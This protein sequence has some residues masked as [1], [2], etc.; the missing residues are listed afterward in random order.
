[1]RGNDVWIRL[2]DLKLFCMD[3]CDSSPLHKH[4]LCCG[5]VEIGKTKKHA[6]IAL[7]TSLAIW[8]A[9]V[10]CTL[11][12]LSGQL[13]VEGIFLPGRHCVGSP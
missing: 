1:M 10:S 11:N 9:L 4:H 7:D 12:G 3:L 6:E 5:F 8:L 2:C 13:H